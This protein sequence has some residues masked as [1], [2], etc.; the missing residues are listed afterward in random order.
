MTRD[1]SK[2]AFVAVTPISDACCVGDDLV[3]RVLR[4]RNDLKLVAGCAD[5]IPNSFAHQRPR[6]GDAKE[7]EPALGSASSSPTIR[8][9]CR[10]PSSRLKVTVLPKATVSVDAGSAMT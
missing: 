5:D 1:V 2:G 9:F 8:Y 3:A 7:I 4:D 6:H 10:R